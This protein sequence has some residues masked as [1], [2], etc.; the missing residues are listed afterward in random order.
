MLQ[1]TCQYEILFIICNELHTLSLDC[2]FLLVHL[3]TGTG[4]KQAKIISK[5]HKLHNTKL[6]NTVANS[7]GI[8]FYHDDQ[9]EILKS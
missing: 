6:H 5:N 1:P 9:N 8:R 2:T 4:F 7:S 3:A